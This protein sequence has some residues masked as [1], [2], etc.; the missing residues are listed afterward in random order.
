MLA[1]LLYRWEDWGPEKGRDLP[2]LFFKDREEKWASRCFASV[3]HACSGVVHHNHDLGESGIQAAVRFAHGC[4]TNT[5]IWAGRG[6]VVH[7]RALSSQVAA[8][9]WGLLMLNPCSFPAPYCWSVLP[10]S[11]LWCFQ[12]LLGLPP[13]SPAGKGQQPLSGLPKKKSTH[14]PALIDAQ[15]LWS[16]LSTIAHQCTNSSRAGLKS[17]T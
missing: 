17:L 10:T 4:A 15:G 8:L 2:N 12:V 11:S 14:V 16:G 5:E 1:S 6:E 9:R 13:L 3:L 7:P